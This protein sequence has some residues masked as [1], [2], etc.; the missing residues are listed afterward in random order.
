MTHVIVKLEGTMS[1]TKGMEQVLELQD[2]MCLARA[3]ET[4]ASTNLLVLSRGYIVACRS[5]EIWQNSE[6]QCGG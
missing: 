2:F 5:R 6:L 1:R 3:S 4:W